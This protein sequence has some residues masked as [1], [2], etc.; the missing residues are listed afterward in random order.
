MKKL[1]I[2]TFATIVAMSMTAN[3]NATTAKIKDEPL[4]NHYA[5]DIVVT[6]EDGKFT[7]RN[8]RAEDIVSEDEMLKFP[9]SKKLMATV[10]ATD[11]EFNCKAVYTAK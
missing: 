7:Y 4:A 6:N 9:V 5:C 8:I 3:A 2:A 10:N 1:F 11:A